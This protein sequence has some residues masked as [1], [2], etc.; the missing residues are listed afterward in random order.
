MMYL[1]GDGP[2]CSVGCYRQWGSNGGAVS[3][4]SHGRVS[5]CSKVASDSLKKR[6]WRPHVRVVSLESSVRSIIVNSIH[7]VFPETSVY[8]A[9]GL[10][11]DKDVGCLLVSGNDGPVGIV[12]QKDVLRRVTSRRVNPELT[13][14]KDVMSSPLI[15]IGQE[16]SIGDAA[17]KMIEMGI[18]RLVVTGEDGDFRGLITM[19][20][21]VRWVANQEKLSDSL[22]DYLMHE[23]T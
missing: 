18:K 3:F 10:M 6:R 5:G 7:R 8:E 12:T 20:D 9:A 17:K 1:A 4:A 22:I 11:V 15:S 21:I 13:K 23:V 19:T 2:N 14:V 16:T